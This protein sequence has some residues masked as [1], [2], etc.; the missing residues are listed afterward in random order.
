[1]VRNLGLGTK[2]PCVV[3]LLSLG[4]LSTHG[5]DTVQSSEAGQTHSGCFVFVFNYYLKALPFFSYI[6]PFYI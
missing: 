5:S 6:E 4:L 1:M 2:S 3:A